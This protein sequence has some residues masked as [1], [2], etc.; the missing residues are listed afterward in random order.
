MY[1]RRSSGEVVLKSE[2]FLLELPLFD[3]PV[4]VHDSKVKIVCLTERKNSM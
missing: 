3:D 1:L 2:D 4:L